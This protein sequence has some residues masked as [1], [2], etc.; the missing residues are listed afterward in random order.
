FSL[1]KGLQESQELPQ[2]LFTPTTKAES[3]HDQPLS[4]DEMKKLV[5]EALAEEMRKKSLALYSY[6]QDYAQA[7]GIIIADTKME[8]GLDFPPTLFVTSLNLLLLKPGLIF[9]PGLLMAPTTITKLK[10]CLKPW[11]EP[12]I[13]LPELTSELLANFPA[14]RIY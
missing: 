14:L 4:M 12:W 13:R 10:P 5:G 6:A 3:G 9:M 2:P 11:A 1:P 7:R 8:F